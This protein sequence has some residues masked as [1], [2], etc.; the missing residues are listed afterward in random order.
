MP[1]WWQAGHHDKELVKGVLAHGFW[2][3]EAIFEDNKLNLDF[4]QSTTL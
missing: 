3:W 2:N 1:S 4:L